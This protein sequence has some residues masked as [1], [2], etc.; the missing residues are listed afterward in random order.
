VGGTQVSETKKWAFNPK[1]NN[2][3]YAS[4]KTAGYKRCVPG[5]KSGSGTVNIVWDPTILLLTNTDA[6]ATPTFSLYLTAAAFYSVPSVVDGLSY[7]VDLDSGDFVTVDLTFTANGAW[8]NPGLGMALP[9][10]FRVLNPDTHRRLTDMHQEEIEAVAKRVAELNKPQEIDIE[11]LVK[12][13][14]EKVLTYA[15]GLKAHE[16]RE[17]RIQGI[18][19]VPVSCMRRGRPLRVAA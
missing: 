17:R 16:L 7:N 9:E 13:A 14:C 11:R 19:T 6:G 12:E 2:P 10:D 8:T 1:A 18:T 4:N 15:Q 3:T 5:I